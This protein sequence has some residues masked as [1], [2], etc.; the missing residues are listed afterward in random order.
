MSSAWAPAVTRRHCGLA[1]AICP[2]SVPKGAGSGSTSIGIWLASIPSD[3]SVMS[4]P[5]RAWRI[6]SCITGT[7]S[8]LKS[9]GRYIGLSAF[10]EGAHERLALPREDRHIGVHGDEEEAAIEHAARLV[11]AHT[12]EAGRFLAGENAFPGVEDRRLDVRVLGIAEMA[13]IGGKV[14]RADEDAV[15]A[16]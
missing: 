13:H 5:S 1:R 14:R 9:F 15:D 3:P 8:S 6:A 2:L 12:E 11:L 7:R 16:V 10:L 4:V